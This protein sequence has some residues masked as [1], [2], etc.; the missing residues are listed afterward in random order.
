[1]G[2]RKL[3]PDPIAHAIAWARSLSPFAHTLLRKWAWGKLSAPDLQELAVA[4]EQS[5]LQDET[6]EELAALGARGRASQNV[7][8]DLVRKVQTGL[9]PSSTAVTIPRLDPKSKADDIGQVPVKLPSQ[10]MQLLEAF[11]IPVHFRYPGEHQEFLE[12]RLQNHPMFRK[13]WKEKCISLLFHSDGAAF[14]N[15]DSLVTCSFRGL[16]SSQ[17]GTWIVWSLEA[18]FHNRWPSEDPEG[19]SLQAHPALES[20]AGKPILKDG[21]FAILYGYM[22]DME[23]FQNNLAHI[24]GNVFYAFLLIG[25]RQRQFRRLWNFIQ[26]HQRESDHGKP[27]SSFAMTNL[28]NPKALSTTYP[29]LQH[30]KAAQVRCLVPVARLLVEQLFGDSEQDR[31]MKAVMKFLDQFYDFLYTAAIIPS[32]SEGMK[33]FTSLNRALQSYQWLAAQAVAD[34]KCLWSMVPKHHY[35]AELAGQARF[36]NPRFVWCYGSED[37]VGTIADLG[38]TCLRGSPTFHMPFGMAEK[39]EVA[40]TLDL[41]LRV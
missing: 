36:L 35:S 21:F 10:W 18:L 16:L 31:H 22:G 23:E 11:D 1:M 29:C 37:Y 25:N 12:P 39:L 17:A 3:L 40:M 38:S 8:R 15:N 6:T 19:K 33:A 26:S 2:K 28:T 24:I 13:N 9:V 27:L 41:A 4:A 5:G 34:G 7:Q 30:V 14:Q 32:G 20:L